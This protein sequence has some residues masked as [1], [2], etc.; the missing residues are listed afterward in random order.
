MYRPLLALVGLLANLTVA[1]VTVYG[2]LGQT[3]IA[4]SATG[5]ATGTN[6]AA[7]TTTSFVTTHG[8]PQYTGLA[9]Y[10]PVFL[11]PPAIPNDP[12]PSTAVTI[13]VPNSAQLMNGLSIPQKPTFFG[14]SIEMSVATQLIGKN[15]TR[16]NVPFL[17][18]M[19]LIAQKAGAVHVRVGGNTQETAFLVDSFP[20]GG[21]LE[22]DNGDKSNPTGTPVLAFTP[23]LIYMLGN[24][25]SLVNVKWYLGVPFNDSTNWRLQIAELGES[26]LGDNLLGFQA[27]NEPDLYGTHNHRPLGY[28]QFDYFGEF[29]LLTQAYQGDGRVTNK[30]SL[31]APSVQGG[32]WGPR[33]EAVWDTGFVQA[34]D[35]YLTALSVEHYPSDNCGVVFPDPKNPPRDPIQMLPTYLTHK[36]GQGLVSNYLNSTMM[37]QTWGKPFLMFETNTASCGGFPGI[38]DAFTSAL[39]AVDYGLQM[40]NSNFTGALLHAGGQNVSYNPFTAPPTNESAI[41][42]WTVGP[43]FYSA[44]VVAEALGTTNTSQVKD[45][46]PDG[47]DLTPA[48]AIYENGNLARMALINFMTDP[49]GAND[50]VAT[51]NI[52]GQQFGEA[53]SVPTQ[54]KVKYLLAPSVSE[55]DNITWA[56]Q[57]LGGRFDVDGRLKGEENV[58]TVPCDQNANTCTIRVPAP[59]VALVFF[60]DAAQQQAGATPSVETFPTTVLTKTKNTVSIDASVLATAQGMS[61]KDRNQQG[62]TSQGGENGAGR[63]GAPWVLVATG[64]LMG[65]SL[66][67]WRTV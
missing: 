34:Y 7:S 10:N 50:F 38:S 28:T 62:G 66:C 39:W 49:S 11:L 26:I 37:A 35:Q 3:T 47:N 48:Y 22:K 31:I 59:G 4:A 61:G 12:A 53:N 23:D 44:L 15:S 52:G 36:N 32:D 43:L 17:N 6:S 2:P 21:I 27:G 20:D 24:V 65:L 57:T 40:A 8:P 19:S 9:A 64:T 29:S 25:S 58:A 33:P 67:I 30:K 54:A 14:F 5:S 18:L 41:H 55:K 1:K 45:L 46:L 42:Q 63:R 56:G 60:S 51:V 16:L 13:A